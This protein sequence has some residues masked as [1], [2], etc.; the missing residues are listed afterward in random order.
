[1]SLKEKLAAAVLASLG[2]ASVG[3]AQSATTATGTAKP[4]APEAK[5]EKCWGI[6]KSSADTSCG[7]SKSDIEATKEVFKKKFAKSVT[8]DCSGSGKCGAAKGH[9][10]WINVPEG[11][12][13]SKS[14]GFLI[15]EKDGKKV[16][17]NK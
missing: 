17:Q 16:V 3:L 13:I 4:A 8:H 9:L 5:Q 7:V 1:M 6:N 12:C 11:T 14:K 10:G 15:V 2:A